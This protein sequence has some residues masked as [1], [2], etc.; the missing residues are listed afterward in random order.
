MINALYNEASLQLIINGELSDTITQ[1]RGVRQG[2]PIS[3]FIFAMFVEPLGELMR[4]HQQELGICLPKPRTHARSQHALITS[5]ADDT[6]LY[7]DQEA[8]LQRA[9]H[10]VTTEF[11]VASGAKL[12]EH[13]T[14]ILS[15]ARQE[16]L[17]NSRLRAQC[18]QGNEWVK[19]LG[20]IYS[21]NVLPTDRYDTVIQKVKLRMIRLQHR[22]PSLA[23]RVLYAN[24]LL[25]SCL[26][27]FAYFIPPTHT[28]RFTSQRHME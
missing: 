8:K 4:D 23:A 28:D 21:E 17:I 7:S 12:N 6:T 24:T 5:F 10:L 18:L 11:C 14:R 1:T 13:K 26:W 16:T 25:S 3:P 19:S 2:C 22:K 9:L 27:Y 20:G 15:T